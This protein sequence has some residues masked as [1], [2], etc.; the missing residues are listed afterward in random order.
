LLALPASAQDAPIVVTPPSGM[1]LIPDGAVFEGPVIEVPPPAVERSGLFGWRRKHAEK[2]RHWQEHVLGY[3][4]EFNEWP[5]GQA[6]YAHGRTEV[7]N[8]QAA[9][10][11]LNEYDFVGKDTQLNFRGE[12]K[13][14]AIAAQLPSS[15]SPLIIEQTEWDPRVA[16]ARRVAILSKLAQGPFPVPA[17]RVV[18]G[19]AVPNGLRGKEAVKVDA[20]R[21]NLFFGAGGGGTVGGFDASGL[22]GPRS[23]G[24]GN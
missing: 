22:S 11:I 14:A 7:A 19:P 6:L 1:T 9:R 2:K 10:M 13:F 24:S 5:L 8:G 3:P 18:V 23:P 17:E 4:D 12:Q 21:Q 16:D 15:F 20:L